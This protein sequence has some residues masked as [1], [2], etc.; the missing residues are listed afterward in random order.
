MPCLSRWAK[1]AFEGANCKTEGFAIPT[2]LVGCA[3]I[4]PDARNERMAK[5]RAQTKTFFF[6]YHEGEIFWQL[7]FSCEKKCPGRQKYKHPKMA[8]P[9]AGLPL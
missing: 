2:E 1:D 4:K 7:A 3:G 9:S 5:W 6:D 8:G